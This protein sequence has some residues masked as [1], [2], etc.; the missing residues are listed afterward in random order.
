MH[1][2]DQEAVRSLVLAGLEDHWGQVDIGLNPDLQDLRTAYPHGR[3]VVVE[4]SGGTILGTGTIVPRAEVT[5]EIVR[6]SVRRTSRRLG[7][8]RMI[9]HELLRTARLWGKRRVVLETTSSWTDVIAF[10]QSCG[11][12]ITHEADGEF[13]RDTWFEYHI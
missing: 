12:K 1:D 9:V 11:F 13:G 6:M 5:A 7:I 3:T 4:G 8:G 2:S 10:Y